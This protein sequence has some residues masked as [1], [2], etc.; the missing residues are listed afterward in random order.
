MVL[1]RIFFYTLIRGLKKKIEKGNLREKIRLGG[2]G[3]S[4]VGI[5]MV[6]K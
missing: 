6:F 1:F 3:G 2:V 5:N 4:G